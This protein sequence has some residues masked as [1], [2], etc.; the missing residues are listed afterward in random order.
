L[1]DSY[2]AGVIDRSEFEPRVAGLKTRVAQLQQRQQDATEAADAERELILVTSQLEDF[3]TKVRAGLDTLDWLGT[4]DII[5][6]LVRRIEID[7]DDIEVVF[8]VPPPSGS[9]PPPP[10]PAGGNA[11]NWQDC[12][13]GR[14]ARIRQG[15][16]TCRY[17]RYS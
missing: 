15:T 12:T 4:R 7:G 1:I 3:A 8:R 9:A 10:G 6:T 11:P 16:W 14:G 17:H 5:R 13:G 2:A